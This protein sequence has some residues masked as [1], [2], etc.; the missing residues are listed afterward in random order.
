MF[1]VCT[2]V[3]GEVLG[4][5]RQRLLHDLSTAR[6][7]ARRRGPVL[8][9]LCAALGTDPLDVP[10][11]AVYLPTAA[12]LRRAATVGCPADLLPGEVDDAG[13]LPEQVGDLGVSSAGPGRTR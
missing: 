12:R 3:T 7:R 9:A 8:S 5:R 6:E 11:A 2:E 10:F 13:R 4:E 1:G